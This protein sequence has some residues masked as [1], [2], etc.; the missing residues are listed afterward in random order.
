[1]PVRDIT[2]FKNVISKKGLSN[3]VNK[4]HV[5]LLCDIGGSIQDTFIIFSLLLHT[6]K[7]MNIQFLCITN[8]IENERK[9]KI[10][11]EQNEVGKC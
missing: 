11:K 6:N 1:M 4:N 5:S 7:H 8:C 9:E 3:Y 10:N 2:T